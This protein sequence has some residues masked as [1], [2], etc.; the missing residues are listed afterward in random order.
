MVGS[1]EELPAELIYNAEVAD[2]GFDLVVS[3]ACMIRG[4]FPNACYGDFLKALRPGGHMAFTIRDIYLNPET[5]N[6]MNFPGALKKLEEEG[7]I[8]K[9]S[10]TQYVKYKGVQLGS[11]HKEEGANVMVWKKK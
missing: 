9:V 11:G 4:H 1:G 8:E 3:A 6:G 7:L 5:D 10:H 2:S